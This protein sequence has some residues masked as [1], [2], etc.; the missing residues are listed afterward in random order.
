MP[1][2]KEVELLDMNFDEAVKAVVRDKTSHGPADKLKEGQ[3][4]RK[5]RGVIYGDYILRKL[6]DSLVV[7][8]WAGWNMPVCGKWLN[9]RGL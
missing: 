8:Q 6:I 7:F 9:D 4:D 1:K 2:V 3:P 5:A